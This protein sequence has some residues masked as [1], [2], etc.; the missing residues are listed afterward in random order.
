MATTKHFTWDC[1]CSFEASIATTGPQGG[2]GGHGGHTTLRIRSQDRSATM[3]VGTEDDP[4]LQVGSLVL[5]FRGDD[6][7]AGLKALIAFLHDFL[8]KPQKEATEGL[9]VPDGLARYIS[10]TAEAMV[11]KAYDLADLYY[12]R[13]G[14]GDG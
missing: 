4:P 14:S 5:T 2:D 8:S 1:C 12:G 13:K 3:Y 9:S 7:M 6:E 10:P 11:K